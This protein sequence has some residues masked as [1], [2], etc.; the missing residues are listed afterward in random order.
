MQV[1]PAMKEEQDDLTTSSHQPLPGFGSN[2]FDKPASE[3]SADDRLDDRFEAEEE[4]LYEEPDRDTDF[5]LGF[6][7]ED[8]DEEEA[9]DTLLPSELE[10]DDA[11]VFAEQEAFLRREVEA[12]AAVEA[13]AVKK[14]EQAW[15]ETSVPELNEEKWDEEPE[16]PAW[17]QPAWADSA[18]V[19]PIPADEPAAVL[20][21]EEDEYMDEDGQGQWPVS[22]I[23][24]GAIALLL[25]VAGVYGVM[26]QR[27]A[28]QEEI[29]QLRA[30]L[31]TAAS[32]DEI[33]NTRAALQNARE[34]NA[35]LESS[36]ANLR[37]D[38]QRLVDTVAGLEAQLAATPSG[39]APAVAK[40]AASKPAVAKPAA[41]PAKA[42]P[43]PAPA[44]SPAA[45][46]VTATTGEWFVN[47]GSYGQRAAAEDWA[48]RL[49]PAAGD[50]IVAPSTRDGRTFYRVRV[51]N[52][53]DKTAAQQVAGKLEYTY[54]VSKLW[55][56]QQ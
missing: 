36:I 30:S 34:H 11:Q 45:A 17:Q 29:R 55:V 43:A 14:L 52:L 7:E 18:P 39:A 26:Q 20:W 40:V 47:F 4:E 16:T 6:R 56:G 44:R 9:F 48:R 19:E 10:E 38:N 25:V 49:K 2:P 32:P 28:T 37:S 3:R 5:S 22:L 46:P 13:A 15:D 21:N 51:I 31:A 23:V 42:A 54:G 33:A 35:Q 27:S 24:V 8:I 41:T 53:P 12:V 50:V 1:L